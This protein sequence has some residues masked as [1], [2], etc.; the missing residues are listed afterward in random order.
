MLFSDEER[1]MYNET[2]G[3]NADIQRYKG[4]GEMDG[5]QLNETTIIRDSAPPLLRSQWPTHKRRPRPLPCLWETRLS[6]RR[7]FI[8][9]NATY[10]QNL[11]V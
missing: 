8:E 10:V 11:D 4:L 2:L 5:K 1:D 9:E 3:G 7:R 6:P